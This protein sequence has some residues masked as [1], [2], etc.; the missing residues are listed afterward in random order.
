M[1]HKSNP[2]HAVEW[3]PQTGRI[4]AVCTS[5]QKGHGKH[6]VARGVLRA[7]HGLEGDAHA[8]DWHRQLSLLALAD[9]EWMRERSQRELGFGSFAENFVLEALDFSAVRVGTR[10][11]LGDEAEIEITQIGK[12]CHVGCA[13]SRQVGTCIM[14]TRGL[15]ARV[16]R[17]GEVAVGDSVTA[18]M[19]GGE[20][21]IPGPRQFV[22]LTGIG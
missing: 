12:E 4:L 16:L 19:P 3:I 18:W 10:F 2:P 15:F 22:A 1:L 8:G 17:G 21:Q 14:P 11:W 5:P 7:A 9:I 13:I 6:P 20:V